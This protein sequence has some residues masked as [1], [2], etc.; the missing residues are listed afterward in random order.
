MSVGPQVSSMPPRFLL[1][2]AC[3]KGHLNINV[4]THMGFNCFLTKLTIF[5]GKSA[6]QTTLDQLT[7]GGV[8]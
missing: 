1:P 4:N 2:G 5:E 3:K 6:Q 8:L 7:L